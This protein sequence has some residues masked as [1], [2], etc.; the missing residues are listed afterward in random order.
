MVVHGRTTM[1]T[2]VSSLLVGSSLLSLLAL[3]GC[4]ADAAGGAD[5]DAAEEEVAESEDAVTSAPSNFGY[6]AVTRRDFRKCA[7]PLCGGFYV[8]RVNDAKTRCAD[9]SLQNECYVS[10]IQLTGV[11]LSAREEADFRTALESGKALIKARTY[12][13]T[14]FGTVV[15]TL[16]ASEGW[17]GAT[18]SA[19][20]GTF[21]RVADNGLRCIK[22]PC[23]STTAYGLNDADDYNV[24]KVNLENTA[25]KAD[26]ESLDRART[27]L[28]TKEGVIIAGGIAIPKCL[29]NTNCGPFAS[30]SEFFLRVVRRE[31]KGCGSRGLST[32]NAG[33]YCS[34]KASDI[35][36][37]FDA[38]GT[39]Q[40]KPEICTQIFAPVCGCD[41]NTY[42]NDCKAAAAGTSVSSSGPCAA[43]AAR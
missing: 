14:A 3:T 1:K 31:G 7:A 6:F 23:P 35:C 42:E 8:K 32:C 41:G 9:G 17:L 28:A 24:I 37:A 27:A 38:G 16:K 12:K 4:T 21:Y 36:G 19:A 30:A 39:C 29:P 33:Q 22:A 10:A 18:G 13:K 26:A 11:G 5:D 43:P 25:I 2:L 40:Y 34:W 15:G 20:N